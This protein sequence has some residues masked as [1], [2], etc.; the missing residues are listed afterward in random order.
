[1]TVRP[2][3][4]I[5]LYITIFLV[6]WLQVPQAY[7]EAKSQRH[8]P[9]AAE[10]YV[11]DFTRRPKAKHLGPFLAATLDL[12]GQKEVTLENILH[13]GSGE[14]GYAISF[15][16]TDSALLT[17]YEAFENQKMMQITEALWT[18]GEEEGQGR[19][20]VMGRIS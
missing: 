5:A 2:G 11:D 3:F 16:G 1:M 14:D 6:L 8:P 20:R 4:L 12:A 19:I 13:Q 10:G 7:Q 17:F 9:I 15:V 18:P